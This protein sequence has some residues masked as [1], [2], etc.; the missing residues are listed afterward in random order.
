MQIY[1][2]C[3]TLLCFLAIAAMFSLG[4]LQ[5]QPGT[6]AV[7]AGA[8]ARDYVTDIL[9]DPVGNSYVTGYFTD[10]ISF[11]NTTL[12]AQGQN[13]IFLAK[14][15]ADGNLL[16]AQR[17]GWFESEFARKLAFDWNDNILLVGD[18]QDS[19]I[20]AGDTILSLDTLW[21]GP[22]AQ[23][24]D[25]YLMEFEPDG[26]P[27]DVFSDG[28]FS[29]ERVYDIE[30]D[31]HA[32]RVLA[33]TWHTLSFWENIILGRG[34]HDGMIVS[35]DSSAQNGVGN[36]NSYF[37]NRNHAWGSQFDEAREVEVIG[38]S[39]YVLAGTFQ[40]TCYFR[41]STLYGITDF[42]DDI[43]LTTH[44][45]T[46]GFRW[47]LWGGSAGKDR[48][49]GLDKDDQGNLYATGTHFGD[50]TIG[51]EVASGS[52][53]LDGFITKIDKDGTV[54]W[55]TSIGGTGFDA[56]EDV[57][58]RS[59]G[60]IIVTGYFQ[61]ELAIGSTV[62]Q[63]F[64]SLDQDLFVASVSTT[65][66]SVNWAWRG[67]GEGIDFGQT[68]E[69]GPANSIYIAGTFSGTTSIGQQDLTSQGSDDIVIFKMD[70]NGAVSTPE[71]T[72]PVKS[73]TLYPNPTSSSAKLAF[74]LEKPKSVEVALYGIDGKLLSSKSYGR[75]ATGQQQLDL[76]LAA[77]APGFYLVKLF[78]EGEALSRKL[79]ITQ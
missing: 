23:T 41:D 14:Y 27:L 12:I 28:W 61:G 6:W 24:Y 39:L 72:L 5:A 17:H 44:D 4:Q 53:N 77:Y 37:K 20:L 42:E 9:V 43:Y 45:D 10:S 69:I 51:S 74:Q 22:Y 70:A 38:D 50:F 11:E 54:V 66:G 30:V 46:A 58:V 52:G 47:A 35:L 13:D 25:V 3:K 21:Y 64:D 57:A 48:M 31:G 63:A 62:L 68:V 59:T 36:I 60:D 75:L 29:S 18:Y 73:L 34:Y 40:D 7:S 78:V 76:D 15:D 33:V 49:T 71:V 2:K 8:G 79:I 1:F 32:D 16:W 65:D 55:A 19:T 56:I 26:T 67:G